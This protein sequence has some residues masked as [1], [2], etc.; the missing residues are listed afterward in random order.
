MMRGTDA[1][2]FDGVLAGLGQSD[3]IGLAHDRGAGLLQVR[4]GPMRRCRA[5]DH[6]A[7]GHL[8][9]RVECAAQ[10]LGWRQRDGI[11]E[12]GERAVGYLAAVHEEIDMA[13]AVQQ[14]EAECER[15]AGHVAT[16]DV[17]QPGDRVGRGDQRHVGALRGNDPGNACALGV[18]ALAGELDRMR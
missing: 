6:D 5:F 18:A 3:R 14:R 10:L 9:Q 17:Q 12:P 8:A 15:R 16:P 4:R 1:G 2:Q 7:L 11:A 13:V